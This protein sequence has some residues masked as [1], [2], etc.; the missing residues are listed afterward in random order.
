MWVAVGFT[1][2]LG[3]LIWKANE[4]WDFPLP[5][6]II[7]WIVVFIGILFIAANFPDVFNPKAMA[8]HQLIKDVRG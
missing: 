1:I 2:A 4:E 5:P 7:K 6:K 3:G 8:I